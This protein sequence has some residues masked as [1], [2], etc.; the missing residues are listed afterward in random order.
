MFNIENLYYIGI[1]EDLESNNKLTY[2]TELSTITI[3]SLVPLKNN[4]GNGIDYRR[5]LEELKLWKYYRSGYNLNTK[6]PLTIER[7]IYFNNFDDTAIYRLIPIVIS[8]SEIE[9][10]VYETIKNILYFSGNIETIIQHIILVTYIHYIYKYK[11]VNKAIEES[12]KVLINLGYEKFKRNYG[13]YFRY[14]LNMEKV[15]AINFEKEKIKGLSLLN[16]ID[17]E[18]LTIE[19]LQGEKISV[20]DVL[21]KKIEKN[22]LPNFFWNMG[23]YLMKLRSSK[24][25]PESIIIKKYILPDIFSFAEG[26]DFYHSLLGQTRVVKKVMKNR[27][28]NMLVQT[29]SGYYAFNKEK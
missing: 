27:N 17:L 28:I 21:S 25:S 10:L 19:Y 18:D 15:F 1:L 26:D 24:I 13:K 16:K 9:V 12:K 3:K 7:D 22:S 4:I 14:E 29:K 8:N 6:N 20:I 5:F 11:D 2:L 23:N